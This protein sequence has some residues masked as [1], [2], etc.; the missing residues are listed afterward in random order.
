PRVP[1]R[2]STSAEIRKEQF[3]RFTTLRSGMRQFAVVYVIEV[4]LP[5][6]SPAWN[7]GPNVCASLMI[8]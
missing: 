4:M 2:T 5:S 7:A 1:E 8:Q 3:F 6:A